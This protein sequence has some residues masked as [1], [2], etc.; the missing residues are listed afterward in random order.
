[1]KILH[2]TSAKLVLLDAETAAEILAIQ[3]QID[4]I[5]N[6]TKVEDESIR[7]QKHNQKIVDLQN[8]KN[9]TDDPEE[10]LNIEKQIGELIAEENRRQLINQ[11]TREKEALQ[12]QIKNVQS[13][14]AQRKEEIEAEKQALIAAEQSKTEATLAGIT[15]R[16]E[17]QTKD[18][19]AQ[20]KATEQAF[21][22]QAEF[23]KAHYEQQVKNAQAAYDAQVKSTNASYESLL[24]TT[25][26]S[27]T[28]QIEKIKKST[29]NNVKDIKDE[30]AK[31]LKDLVK[32]FKDAGDHSSESFMKSMKNMEKSMKDD[33]GKN[34]MRGLTDGIKSEESTLYSTIQDIANK[35]LETMKKTWDIHSPSK[36]FHFFGKM[37]GLGVVDGFESTASNI[38]KAIKNTLD[39]QPSVLDLPSPRIGSVADWEDALYNLWDSE[40]AFTR[41]AS[42]S[43]NNDASLQPVSNDNRVNVTVNLQLD[44]AMFADSTMVNQLSDQ[45]AKKIAWEVK[46][47]Q[48]TRF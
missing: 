41:Q 47:Q 40:K 11:R 13:A 36:K 16:S 45:V 1:M 21:T 43:R 48:N 30:S 3:N 14:A 9:T 39:I 10:R 35:A 34:I 20:I 33:V 32:L 2:N 12:E 5:D 8:K 4:A 26:K 44:R 31:T 6:L 37:G 46:Q 25:E 29:I 22:Q 19:E 18:L 38:N 27:Y 23:T 17:A 7:L 15:A 42:S 24:D 28:K